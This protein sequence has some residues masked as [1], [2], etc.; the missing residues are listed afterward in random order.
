MTFKGSKNINH[1]SHRELLSYLTLLIDQY[2]KADEKKDGLF[3]NI[4]TD[5]REYEALLSDAFKAEDDEA[6][7]AFERE[8]YRSFEEVVDRLDTNLLV[9]IRDYSL[10]LNRLGMEEEEALKMIPEY[11][12]TWSILEVENGKIRFPSARVLYGHNWE[13]EM[14]AFLIGRLKDPSLKD[15]VHMAGVKDA[16]ERLV[17][18]DDQIAELLSQGK[19]SI[20]GTM[21]DDIREKRYWVCL[22][23][24]TLE[25]FLGGGRKYKKRRAVS[26]YDIISDILEADKERMLLEKFSFNDFSHT[27]FGPLI[28]KWKDPIQSSD[29]IV[30]KIKEDFKKNLE[31]YQTTLA[32]FQSHPLWN[33]LDNYEATVIRDMENL[34]LAISGHIGCRGADDPEQWEKHIESDTYKA[35]CSLI[36]SIPHSWYDNLKHYERGKSLHPSMLN[37]I[38]ETWGEVEHRIRLKILGREGLF[39]KCKTSDQAARLVAER[40][41]RNREDADLKRLRTAR[42]RLIIIF[43]VSHI[44]D[45]ATS[46]LL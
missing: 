29:T 25:G 19:V 14:M 18:A 41:R 38:L 15:Q 23:V 24:Q 16:A 46:K 31:E 28:N 7:D 35:A 36:E 34:L 40:I 21:L 42:S 45:K 11:G 4:R 20:T 44:G 3:D 8:R 10:E 26:V 33:E 30:P 27:V 6:V 37:A 32:A 13:P 5:A 17:R 1:L 43:R 2:T 22:C 12:A 9:Y 39:D